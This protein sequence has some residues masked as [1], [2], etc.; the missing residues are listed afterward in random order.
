MSSR[1]CTISTVSARFRS[2]ERRCEP[3]SRQSRSRASRKCRAA[4][5]TP[6]G[7]Q[8][9]GVDA[10]IAEELPKL[11]A[12]FPTSPSWPTSAAFRIEEYVEVCRKLDACGQVGWLEVNISCPNV[13]GGGMS[14]GTDPE[15]RR[16]GHAGRQGRRPKSPS[17]SSSRPTSRALQTSRKACED[18]GAD[19]SQPYQHRAGHAH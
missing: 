12:R 3:R 8:N 4:C 15:G 9:P 5:S 6:S 18:A 17:S 19:G 7:L 14:F 16:A 1:S 13:H 2:R 11:A 10:V